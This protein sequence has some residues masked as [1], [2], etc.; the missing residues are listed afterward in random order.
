MSSSMS[1]MSTPSAAKQLAEEHPK[2]VVVK[3]NSREVA[4]SSV[5]VDCS[6]IDIA[7]SNNIRD[8][9]NQKCASAKFY[10]CPL[11]GG[12]LG[13][14]NGTLAFMLGCGSDDC[15]I[16]VL[17]EI[18][19]MMGNPIILCGGPSLSLLA[20]FC[21]NYCSGLITIATSEAFNIAISHGM[22][23]R[24]LHKIFKTS[25]AGSTI[26]D[27]WNPVPG[28]Y[29]DAP[30][31]HGYQGG[32][33]I[34]LMRKDFALA[35]DAASQVGAR[36]TLADTALKVYTEASEDP[37][38]KDLDSRVIFRYLGGNEDWA[39]DRSVSQAD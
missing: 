38:C 16:E 28:L 26:N 34:Q 21:N 13:A 36:L 15:N 10:D 23:P 22:D 12:S 29:P 27:K 6:T 4:A 33:R 11:S 31:S 2:R 14:E 9:V 17:E 3:Q 19:S 18:L 24:V 35:V 5:F 37:S 20:K 1:F 25:T 8:A 7:T 32:F 30:A 39:V